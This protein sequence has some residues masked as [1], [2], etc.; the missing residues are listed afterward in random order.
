[1]KVLL[2]LL[3]LLVPGVVSGPAGAASSDPPPVL[4][5]VVS[6][7]ADAC[8][9]R[10][11][12]AVTAEL[13]AELQTQIA[14]LQ[15]QQTSDHQRLRGQLATV[16]EQLGAAQ[17]QLEQLLAAVRWD[18]SRASTTASPPPVTTTTARP[19]VCPANW[20]RRGN[21]CYMVSPSKATWLEA[22]Q[23]CG[24]FDSRARL[25]SI[26]H[27][28]KD[29]IGRL[30]KDRNEHNVWIGL[31]R[32]SGGNSWGWIDGTP[33][34]YT[35]WKRGEPN[36]FFWMEDCVTMYTAGP[37]LWNDRSCSDRHTFV[38]QFALY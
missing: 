3:L 20:L 28:N 27:Y 1:M 14:A 33:V 22:D 18:E 30:P 15:T 34:D 38:C 6:G 36:N 12:T 37:W 17:R 29:D 11:Q 16:E 13:R 8:L 7:L 10:A 31:H 4:D 35:N 2:L 25:A 23:A 32:L 9:E 5:S 26:H 19:R 21:R 24:R